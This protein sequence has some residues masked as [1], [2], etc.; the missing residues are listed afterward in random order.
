MAVDAILTICINVAS[1][2]VVHEKVIEKHIREELPFMATENIMMDAVKKGGDRQAI[3]EC[4]RQLSLEAGHT[5]KE[6]GL[7][8]DLLDRLAAE[9]M[10]GLSL[11]ELEARMDPAAY[12]GRCPQQVEEFLENHVQPVLKKYASALDKEDDQLKV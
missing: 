4:I 11:E 12:I 8:N 9:P 2:L 5:V 3:H 10:L 1:G 6:L 7:P